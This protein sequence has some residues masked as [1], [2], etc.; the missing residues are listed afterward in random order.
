MNFAESVK[1][2]RTKLGLSYRKLSEETG[3]SHSHIR[4]IENGKYTPSFDKAIKL[5]NAL[6]IN[7]QDVI[8]TT[9]QA[10]FRDQIYELI[11]T[12]DEYKVS[13][14]Y[15]EWVNSNLPIQPISE[16]RTKLHDIAFKIAEPLYSESN[17]Q[18]LNKKLEFIDY[19]SNSQFNTFTYEDTI[20]LMEMMHKTSLIQGIPVAKNRVNGFMQKLEEENETIMNNRGDLND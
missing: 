16:D 11:K 10:Q 9:Y 4:D 1:N 6:D 2:N 8:I 12:C 13:I 20:R 18:V 15:K 14:P 7:T 19:I 5:A 3:I 17:K